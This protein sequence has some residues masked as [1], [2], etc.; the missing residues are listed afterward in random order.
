MSDLLQKF[1]KYTSDEKRKIAELKVYILTVIEEFMKSTQ[2]FSEREDI[3]EF[4]DKWNNNLTYLPYIVISRKENGMMEICENET[5]L[6][7]RNIYTYEYDKN[8]FEVT[9]AFL[10]K[11][12]S[13]FE[14]E[15]GT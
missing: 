7:L 10:T 12:F 9:N 13:W 6:S 4:L 1:A 8:V 5:D 2:V 3:T 14:F 15:I 11:I